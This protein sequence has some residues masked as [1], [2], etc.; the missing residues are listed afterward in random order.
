M[1]KTENL[2]DENTNISFLTSQGKINASF[3][4]SAE[5]ENS[6][7]CKVLCLH[8][9][10]CD[11]RIFQYLGRTLSK[12]GIDTF[13]IDLFGHGKSDGKRGD[14][15]F[16]NALKGIDEVLS[17]ILSK[18]QKE[19]DT[20]N[21]QS[22]IY[23]LAHS[24]GCTYAMWYLT[25]FTRRV[26]GLILLAPYVW[27]KEIKNKGEAVPVTSAFYNL[28][29]RRIFTPSKLVSAKKLVS[30]SILQTKEVEVMINDPDIIN[31]YSYR[32]IIDVI[33]FRNTKVNKLSSLRTPVL[34]LHGKNDT[35]VNPQI[36]ERFYSM[37]KCDKKTIKLMDCD[38][39]FNHAIFFNQDDKRYSEVDRLPITNSIID[40]I[41]TINTEN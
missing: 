3:Y 41:N 37:L 40:W 11:A 29:L 21:K 9:F 32:Y 16:N 34:I 26:S 30:D 19:T 23:L 8:G 22:S 10:C 31:C 4:P 7:N 12:A 14:P 38:H 25:S 15:D 1:E 35:N 27:I 20:Q 18:N 6:L 28:L 5:N 33:G 13:A 2:H 39:W 24:L 36:S 17:Q